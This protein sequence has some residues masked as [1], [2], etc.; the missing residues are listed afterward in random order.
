MPYVRFLWQI[1]LRYHTVYWLGLRI[2]I[3]MYI[4]ISERDDII[5]SQFG[6]MFLER[7]DFVMTLWLLSILF[8][9]PFG[10]DMLSSC[11]QFMVYRKATSVK[12]LCYIIWYLKRNKC[13]VKLFYSVFNIAKGIDHVMN[14]FDNSFLS[15]LSSDIF[16]SWKYFTL[17]QFSM[18]SFCGEG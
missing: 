1:R 3:C 12:N 17:S 4:C 15:Y 7:N 13:A 10:S 6:C 8:Q 2:D 18:G 14:P 5:M 9:I 16:F 11:I